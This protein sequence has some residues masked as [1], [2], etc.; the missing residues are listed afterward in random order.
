MKNFVLSF[1][2]FTFSIGLAFSQAAQFK[3]PKKE[4][5]QQGKEM[6]AGFF[7]NLRKKD[8]QAN[9]DF[10]VNSLGGSWEESKKITE[11]NSYLNKFQLIGMENGLYGNLHGTDLIEEGFLPGTDRYFRHTYLGYFDNSFLVFEFRFYVNPAGKVT[12]HYI[13]WSESNPFE[14][15]ATGDMLLPMY[16]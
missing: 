6:A 8:H 11:R 10:I 16:D 4:H 2:F 3:V 14:Y 13:G 5:L 7:E 15:M 9:A 1:L 12:L